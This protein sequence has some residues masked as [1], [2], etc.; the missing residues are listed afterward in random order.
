MPSSRP[1][2]R[3]SRARR[4]ALSLSL[5]AGALTSLVVAAPSSGATRLPVAARASGT[6]TTAAVYRGTASDRRI[7]RA[8]SNRAAPR[9]FGRYFSGTVLDVE[10]NRVVWSRYGTTGRMPASTAKLVT[11][12]NALSLYGP[13]HRFTTTVQA[14][15]G[16]AVVTLVGSGDPSLSTADLRV[17]AQ[18]TAAELKAHGRTS[19]LL[20]FDDYL[21]AAPSRASG[22]LRTYVPADV[23][24]VRALV[25]DG[26]HARDTSLDAA[27]V[28]AA[29]LRAQGVAV[30]SVRRSHARAGSPV[31]ASVQGDRL[32]AIVR[33][34][35]LVSDND[36]AEAL[37]RLVAVASHRPTT[38]AGAAMAQRVT[39]ARDGITLGS[40]AL[41][42][43]SGLSRYDRLT[44]TQLAQVVDNFLEPG[45]DDLAVL[46]SGGLPLAGRTG[47]LRNRFRSGP[48]R[49]A[50]GKI[51]AK[52]GSLRD[53][54]SLA[55]YTRG[56][57]GRLKAFAFVVNYKTAD[58]TLRQRIDLLA[59]TV[60]GCY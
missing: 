24:W 43:G 46:R 7:A 2:R 40:G 51:A 25:V 53:T 15:Y 52:T 27:T 49:C 45:Q 17:L 30:P 37:N 3:L 8:L 1:L 22:W 12:T 48:A 4:A 41:R 47:T 23:R 14:S 6:V 21:F 10:S 57:D 39:L 50:A 13:D 32:D 20:G 5:V 9:L 19:V 38:W 29:L 16:Y 34:M 54:V 55:G 44:T 31:V 33:Q 59:A 36:H 58:S 18:Q 42:D 26:H 56:T 35:M 11:A 60:N 28:F